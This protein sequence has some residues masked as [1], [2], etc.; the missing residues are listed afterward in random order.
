MMT[1]RSQADVEALVRDYYDA[2]DHGRPLEG[3]YAADDEAG[4]LGPAVK[5]G[6]GVGEVVV[7]YAAIR[8]EMQR[9]V[10]SFSENRLE[11]RGL[12]TRVRGEVG[13]FADQVWWS[14]TTGGERFASLT[15]WS[16]VC[17]WCGGGWKLVQLHVSEEV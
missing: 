17:V 16:G 4:D 2:L 8:A 11:S 3:F 15:R 10:A 6:S 14:G 5:I 7:G 9:V 13:W 12:V 1:G